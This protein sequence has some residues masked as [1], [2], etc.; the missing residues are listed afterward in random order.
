MGLTYLVVLCLLVIFIVSSSCF[1]YTITIFLQ[2]LRYS[3]VR[4]MFN[5][6]TVDP[7]QTPK[8]LNMVENDILKAELCKE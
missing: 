7:A 2:G 6:M 5:G 8:F 4:Y 1:T 3:T